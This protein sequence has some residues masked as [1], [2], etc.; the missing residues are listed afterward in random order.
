TLPGL[1]QDEATTKQIVE[2]A[3]AMPQDLSKLADADRTFVVASPDRMALVA[4]KVREVFPVNREDYQDAAA[5]PRFR[6][7]LVGDQKSSQDMLKAFGPDALKQR[8]GLKA[9]REEHAEG[10]TPA[11]QAPAKAG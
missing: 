9:T 2:R 4:V 5:N 1:G 11:E 6:A 8:A 10:E 7:S 3:L